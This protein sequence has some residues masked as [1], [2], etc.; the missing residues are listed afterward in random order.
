M[1]R[2]GQFEA[3]RPQLFALAYRALGSRADAED[4]LQDAYLRWQNA[5]GEIASP[6]AYLMTVVSRLSLDALQSARRKREQYVGVWLPEPVAG[7][8]APGDSLEMTESLSMA[9]LLLLESLQPAERVAFLLREVFGYEYGEL[10]GILETS[11]TN[12]RQLV[13]RAKK[14]VRA[15]RPKFEVN[16]EQ[17]RAALTRF[18]GALTTGDVN[19]L[20]GLLREDVVSYADG[21]G[22]ASAAV[23]PIAGSDKVSRFFLG[24]ARKAPT[25]V[26]WQILDAAGT[27]ALWLFVD[28]RIESIFNLELD[29]DGRVRAIFVTRNPDKFPTSERP[30]A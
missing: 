12:A 7:S 25:G 28:D 20:L 23:N 24:V 8:P 27:P 13:S 4:V 17:H 5:T 26:S 6:K 30:R 1:D 21:G 9:F 15:G 18:I 11:E 16:P 14:H 3:L 2:L 19:D 22:K 10:A 29:H